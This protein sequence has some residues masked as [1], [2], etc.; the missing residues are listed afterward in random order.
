MRRFLLLLTVVLLLGGCA[1]GQL[2]MAKKEVAVGNHQQAIALLRAELQRDST[3]VVAYE[4]LGASYEQLHYPDSAIGVYSM[5]LQLQPEHEAAKQGLGR[6]HLTLAN[7]ARDSGAFRD[8]LDHYARAG[9]F[10]PQNA[11]IYLGRGQ[12]YLRLSRLQ[13]AS[14]DFEQALALSPGDN[15]AQLALEQVQRQRGEAEAQYK[16]GAALYEKSRWGAATTALEQAVAIDADDK[17]VR[18]LLHMAR[19]RRLYQKGSTAA[20]WDAI[21]EFGEAT[22]ARPN[23]AAPHYFMGQ[24]YEKK[25]RNDFVQPIDCYKKALVSEPESSLAK[26][27]QQRIDYL[28][29][30]KEKLEKFWGKKKN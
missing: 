8:A 18:Y 13:K 1:A 28:T 2:G 5:L 14:A 15:A 17:E 7:A 10:A 19:G 23:A 9:E 20:L 6:S 21:V 16:R 11:A 3:N 27:A 29:A 22:N 24:A 4:L 25:D 26:K 30:R 12:T